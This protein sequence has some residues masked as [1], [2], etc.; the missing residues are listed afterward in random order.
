MRLDVWLDI[1]CLFKTRSE[2]QKAIKGGKVDVNKQ[3]GKP[4]KDLKLGDELEITRPMG[5][6]QRV[7]VRG[8]TEQHIAK[9]EARKLYEDVTPAPSP[10]EAEM[11]RLAR[12]ARPHVRAAKGAPNR[13]ERRQLRRMKEGRGFGPRR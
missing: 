10:E 6:R 13:D 2:A 9:A 5:R 3:T 7:I 4:Q 8:F 1:T 11:L 12:L